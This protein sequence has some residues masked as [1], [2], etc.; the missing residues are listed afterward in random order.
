[1]INGIQRGNF[2]LHPEGLMHLSEGCI[3]VVSPFEFD[4]LQRYIRLRQP[5]LP[6]PGSTMRAYGTV[7][8]K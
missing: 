4:N 8:V 2:R 5:D 3:T 6:V 7:D 1:M